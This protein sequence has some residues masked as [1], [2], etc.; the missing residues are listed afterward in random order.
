MKYATD[1]ALYKATGLILGALSIPLRQWKI[2][3][4]PRVFAEED[5]TA[6]DLS[7]EPPETL[8][9]AKLNPT[10][11]E[12]FDW[13][14]R[15]REG[16]KSHPSRK[17]DLVY[18]RSSVPLLKALER[19]LRLAAEAEG[20][21]AKFQRF[22]DKEEIKDSKE[23][24]SRL[25]ERSYELLRQISLK[26]FP[27]DVLED[28]LQRSAKLFAG[29]NEG[30]RLLDFL[31]H[32][33]SEAIPKRQK[34][35]V[36]NLIEEARDTGI[37]LNARFAVVP[38]NL[39]KEV[40]SAL[41]I[42]QSCPTEV[43]IDVLARAANCSADELEQKLEFYSQEKVLHT[44]DGRW[45]LGPLPLDLTVSNPAEILTRSLTALLNSLESYVHSKELRNQILNIVSL[46][47]KCFKSNPQLVANVFVKL[48]KIVKRLGDKYLV[49]RSANLSAEAT[50]HADRDENIIKAEIK[51]RICGI[52]W[53]YQRL[54]RL[55]E[56][57]AAASKSR[58]LAELI[59]SDEDLA[60]CYKCLGRLRRLEAEGLPKGETRE[61]KLNE[62]AGL[63]NKA[64]GYFSRLGKFGP[65]DPEVGDCHSLLGRTYLVAGDLTQAR[66]EISKAYDKI[67]DTSSKDYIDLKILDGDV[68]A[69]FDREAAENRYEQ[70]I[71]FATDTSSE[72]SEMR[73][74]AFLQRG[75]NLVARTTQTN[76]QKY[77][78]M[79]SED[80]KE[81]ARIWLSLGEIK[82]AAVAQWEEIL[83]DDQISSD[84]F[85]TLAQEPIPVK[86]KTVE[87]LRQ[88]MSPHQ[89]KRV[90]QRAAVS[91]EFLETLIKKARLFVAA[92]IK[93]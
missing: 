58:D 28:N 49:L 8:I 42:L 84:T 19:L 38:E 62:S 54:G 77:K 18:S 76:G 30:E 31:F 74:R 70:A 6:W 78:Q 48:D 87:L 73:A 14:S 44:E 92:E 13:L 75:R 64:I 26:N 27:E 16:A 21:E 63:L 47:E 39:P 66:I 72:I 4:E 60:F 40:A 20:D 7:I 36:D 50:L 29:E 3:F 17:F 1:Y 61:A 33:F 41:F 43:Y 69:H 11:E 51:A 71:D 89:G 79:A 83:L 2:G 52:S 22:V 53:A 93:E 9:E 55:E 59:G 35:S 68:E 25:G 86:V 23:I 67:K 24:L 45:S 65:N 10:K 12:I 37:Q 57:Q 81:A 82:A 46:A 32:K 80:F 88:S 85:Q 5:L 34:L 91:R 15:V 56:A 90:A